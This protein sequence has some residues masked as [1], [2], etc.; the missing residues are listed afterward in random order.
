MSSAKGP[1]PDHQGEPV[2]H[3]QTRPP[4]PHYARYYD[5]AVRVGRID[6]T[7]EVGKAIEAVNMSL[8]SYPDLYAHKVTEA[9]IAAGIIAPDQQ[10]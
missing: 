1:P 6:V 3:G 10:S 9:L 4:Q 2:I 8:R 5:E 7:N